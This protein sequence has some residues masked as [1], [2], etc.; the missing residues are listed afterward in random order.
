[1]VMV[2]KKLSFF[3]M[4]ATTVAAAP[5][6]AL[7]EPVTLHCNVGDFRVGDPMAAK[8]TKASFRKDSYGETETLCDRKLNVYC[9]ADRSNPDRLLL[10]RT[11]RFGHSGDG[12]AVL[13]YEY[14]VDV[15][16]RTVTTRM[17]DRFGAIFSEDAVSACTVGGEPS[18]A[19]QVATRDVRWPLRTI[20][21]EDRF[22][23]D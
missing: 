23:T 16:S 7:A 10:K 5:M 1:M 21:D 17:T 18:G 9:S 2:M 13:T 14:A 3:A 11:V 15:Q 20:I 4:L 19:R 12:E 8:P 6:A 22:G